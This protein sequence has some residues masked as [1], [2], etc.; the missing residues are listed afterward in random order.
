MQFFSRLMLDIVSWVIFLAV[1]P[2]TFLTILKPKIKNIFELL[3]RTYSIIIKKERHAVMTASSWSY[4][5]SSHGGVVPSAVGTPFHGPLCHRL[6][7]SF[8]LNH[9][10]QFISNSLERV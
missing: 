2:I 7:W 1:C 10:T 3:F 5:Q 6:D 4:Y 8:E 9:R